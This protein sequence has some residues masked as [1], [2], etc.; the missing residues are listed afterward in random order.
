M[1][2]VPENI[3]KIVSDAGKADL[4]GA[5][6][7]RIG[8]AKAAITGL[9]RIKELFN[10]AYVGPIQGRLGEARSASLE[11]GTPGAI[12]DPDQHEFYS[13]V[14]N[15]KNA[16]I[17]AITGAQMSEPEAKRIMGQLPVPTFSSG[18][19]MSNLE[20][21][22]QSLRDVIAEYEELGGTLSRSETLRHT[23]Q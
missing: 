1:S 9:D 14:T 22:Q 23:N 11:A 4:S 13:Q 8:D 5:M 6:K 7:Q 21:M 2:G 20:V 17:K 18:R 10:P 3:V 19:F 15:V 12:T 16:A